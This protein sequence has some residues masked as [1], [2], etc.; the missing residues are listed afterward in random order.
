M[1]RWTNQTSK[2]WY[3]FCWCKAMACG[4]DGGSESISNIHSST[5]SRQERILSSELLM[6]LLQEWS[7]PS[8]WALQWWRD[9]QRGRGSP[10]EFY[11]LVAD[12]VY[13][14]YI[15]L[16]N[17]SNGGV[18][19]NV[20]WVRAAAWPHFCGYW[21][22]RGGEGRGRGLVYRRPAGRREK[23]LWDVTRYGDGDRVARW[24]GPCLDQS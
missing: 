17:K 14:C 15:H 18:Y 2:M 3:G 7:K 16:L 10:L 5:S 13:S 12:G 6:I 22:R 23:I 1:M 24:V 19:M 9:R 21:K 11:L 8:S 4:A 20:M